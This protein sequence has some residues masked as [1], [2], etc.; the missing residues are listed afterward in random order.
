MRTTVVSKQ[1]PNGDS[2]AGEVAAGVPHG[3][4]RYTWRDGSSYDGDWSAGKKHGKGTFQWPSQAVYEGD[5]MAGVM[6]G[7][8]TYRSPNGESY[9][10]SWHLNQKHG[11]GKKKYANGD[12]YD[13]LWQN[14]AFEGP[15]RYIWANGNSYSGNWRGGKMDGR[16]IFVW[17]NRDR[18]DGEWAGGRENGKGVFTWADGAVFEGTWLNGLRHGRGV[19]YPPGALRSRKG[20]RKDLMPPRVP[21]E[22]PTSSGDFGGGGRA[23]SDDGGASS[24][25][26]N[27][28]GNGMDSGK[29]GNSESREEQGRTGA[30]GRQASEEGAMNPPGRSHPDGDQ[31]RVG[32]GDGDA[33]KLRS[34]KVTSFSDWNAARTP[35]AGASEAPHPAGI[36]EASPSG[37][38]TIISSPPPSGHRRSISADGNSFSFPREGSEPP[39]ENGRFLTPASP[40]GSRNS[41][42]GLTYDSDTTLSES[43]FG[44]SQSGASTPVYS[45]LVPRSRLAAQR[46]PVPRPGDGLARDLFG[47]SSGSSFGVQNGTSTENGGGH[48]TPEEDS[49]NRRLSGMHAG[50]AARQSVDMTLARNFG[51]GRG[52]GGMRCVVVR[53]Y[54]EGKL[55]SEEEQA[56]PEAEARG[57]RVK[58]HSRRGTREVKRPGETI[59]KGHRSY[60]LML[61]LQTGIR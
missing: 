21:E 12:V 47:Q 22:T 48:A 60:D 17:A 35:L 10:G 30:D 25:E 54:V 37:D 24:R 59:F 2:Y 23:E 15:G 52:E 38:K 31:V 58:R 14:G 5:W 11:L 57:E 36:P 55:V 44:D 51:G 7:W 61:N 9:R 3:K 33:P 4:G 18:Y 50:A 45:P 53:E 8:G 13:G 20:S 42:L 28:A 49:A 56:M 6:E 29:G 27:P 1:F 16:G 43:S 46:P 32:E 39:P 40:F 41:A 34:A 19:Y 26:Q